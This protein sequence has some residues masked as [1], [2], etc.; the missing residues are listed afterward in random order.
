MSTITLIDYQ[1]SG[2]YLTYKVQVDQNEYTC[3]YS[4]RDVSFDRLKDTYG[5]QKIHWICFHIVAFEMAKF[6]SLAPKEIDFGAFKDYC[7]S[8]FFELWCHIVEKVWGQWRYENNLPEHKLPT[9]S[10]TLSKKHHPLIDQRKINHKYLLFCGG[11]KDSLVAMRTLDRHKITYGAFAYTHTTY[12]DHQHQLMLLENQIR[13]TG[14]VDIH[15]QNIH[16]DFMNISQH[17]FPSSGEPQNTKSHDIV[18]AE[19]PCSIFASL[20]VILEKGYQNAVLAH[21][22]S[23]D[24]GNLIWDATGEEI[25]HQWGKSWQAEELLN[26][27]IRENLVQNFSYFSIL[28]PITDVVI[29]NLLKK[30]NELIPYVHSCNIKKPWCKKCAKCAYVWLGMK[31]YLPNQIID[32]IFKIDLFD[33]PENEIWFRQMLGL[34]KHTPFECVGQI[35]EARLALELYLKSNDHPK[36]RRLRSEFEEDFTEIVEELSTPVFEQTNIENDIKNIIHQ[37]YLHETEKIREEL[38]NKIEPVEA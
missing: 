23:A 13:K 6:C 31:A 9:L 38:L 27:Y 26:D 18:H 24:I 35:S 33:I 19:T 4:Y 21:E 2:E 20:P 30:E 17:S 37:Y 7:T 16:D 14:A 8:S 29:F 28:K 11:G 32:N 3:T 34:E 10:H 15:I 1:V 22:R 36:A 5:E 12:G 25:N